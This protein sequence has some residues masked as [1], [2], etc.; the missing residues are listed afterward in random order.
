[1]STIPDEL[2]LIPFDSDGRAEVVAISI[3]TGMI[4]HDCTG[5]ERTQVINPRLLCSI[6]SYFM[7]LVQITRNFILPAEIEDY[8][9]HQIYFIR[10]AFDGS[11][12]PKC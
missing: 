7:I 6:I 12:L 10:S 11:V 4:N 1:M 8:A 5:E 9:N 3:Q 2:D